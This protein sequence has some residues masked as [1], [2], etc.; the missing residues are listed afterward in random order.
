MSE[1]RFKVGQFVRGNAGSLW[2]IGWISEGGLITAT[3]GKATLQTTEGWWEPALPRKGEWWEDVGCNVGIHGGDPM[4]PFLV[5]SDWP[6]ATQFGVDC[7][8]RPVNFGKGPEKETVTVMEVWQ[9]Q[10]DGKTTKSLVIDGEP[11]V[12]PPAQGCEPPLA[13]RN[14]EVKGEF[15][16][17]YTF[18][19]KANIGFYTTGTPPIVHKLV[20]GVE[21]PICKYA[22]P[23]DSGV[24]VEWKGLPDRHAMAMDKF[25]YEA[26]TRKANEAM[27]ACIESAIRRV[28]R[29]RLAWPECP[30][31]GTVNAM[32]KGGRIVFVCDRC[33]T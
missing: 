27:V 2:L 5:D 22:T 17:Y 10:P 8:L 32:E 29:T 15:R 11:V 25:T 24:E 31:G 6:K 33:S 30:Y 12:L 1:A 14:P 18:D 13:E 4:P 16:Q 20:D 19:A 28:K 3:D 23:Q 21:V 7:H 9:R 26:S